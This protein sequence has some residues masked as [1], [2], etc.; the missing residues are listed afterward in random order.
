MS[1]KKRLITLVS[2]LLLGLIIV[3][4]ISLNSAISSSDN[5]HQIGERRIPALL[6]LSNLNVERMNIR[7]Q[8]LEVL[9]LESATNVQERLS[10]IKQKLDGYR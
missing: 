8:T 1:V 10:I 4:A 5:M 7:A 3:G 2:I 6:A 9:T